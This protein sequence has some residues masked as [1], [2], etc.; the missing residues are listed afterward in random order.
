[1]SEAGATDRRIIEDATCLGCACLCDDIGVVVEGDRIVEARNACEIGRGWYERAPVD[2]LVGPMIGG[3]PAPLDEALDRASGVLAAAKAPVVFG[4]G[5]TIEAQRIAVAI[6]DRIGAA[7]APDFHGPAGHDAFQ[8]FGAVGATLGEI[9]DRADLIVFDSAHWPRSLPRFLERF[10]DPPGR[11]VPEG[12]A[13][14]TVITFPGD[15]VRFTTDEGWTRPPDIIF[16]FRA[17]QVPTYTVLRALVNGVSFDPAAFEAEMGAPLLPYADLAERLRRA[18]YGVLIHQPETQ[19]PTDA[20]AVS[21]LIRDLNRS[22]RFVALSPSSFAQT[23]AEAVLAWQ[24]GSVGH[25]DF[26]PGYPR[27]LPDGDVVRRIRRCEADVA[28]VVGDISFL[29]G[30][31]IDASLLAA[32]PTIYVGRVDPE[33]VWKG[34]PGWNPLRDL[35]HQLFKAETFLPTSRAGIDAGGT[36]ARF[37]GVMLPLRPPFPGRRPSQAEILRGI[38]S[39][40][41]ALQSGREVAR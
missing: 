23:A 19:W 26:A 15:D 40:L 32:I 12:R 2:G 9:R 14:R 28:L 22:T 41:A 33:D 17:S 25:V 29:S 39:R 8:R 37:D 7:V 4:L 38:D 16:D 27:P 36:V 13:G 18:R 10:V 6:A 5:A 20:E 11:F 34:D 30:F 35:R 3:R 31:R 24:A 21:A 1:M